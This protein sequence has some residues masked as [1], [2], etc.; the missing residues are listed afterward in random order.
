VAPTVNELGNLE[1]GDVF[2]SSNKISIF[3]SPQ[4]VGKLL[5]QIDLGMVSRY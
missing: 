2:R 1:P 3:R 4:R 5:S